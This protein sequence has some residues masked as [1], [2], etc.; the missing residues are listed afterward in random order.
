MSRIV[1]RVH[2]AGVYFVT[3][4]T[5]Q[6]RALFQKDAAAQVLLAQILS[7]RDR[8]F[9]DLHAFVI[10][11]DHLHLLLT[12]AKNASLEK[13]I[14]MIKG[15]SAYRI[16]KELLYSFPIW[17][18][19]FHDRWLRTAEEFQSRFDYI[20]KNPVFARLVE[21]APD[22]QF[23]SSCGRFE[24]DFSQFDAGTSGAE[25]PSSVAVDVAVKTA[26]H[27]TRAAAK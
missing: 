4:H 10:M 1:R 19:G 16:R 7:C 6:R 5:W 8:G 18:P 2:Q 25:A 11:P 13:A 3:T 20:A 23:S 21:S 14:Q 9:Y 27:K 24:L 22:Y 26:T 17:Q 12:P 15:S